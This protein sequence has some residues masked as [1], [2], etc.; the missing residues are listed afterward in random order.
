MPIKN[1][2]TLDGAIEVLNRALK[3]DPD[4]V[5]DLFLNHKVQCNDKMAEDE[6]IQVGQRDGHYTIGPLGIINGIFGIDDGVYNTRFGAIAAEVDLDTGKIVKFS[7]VDYHKVAE[8]IAKNKE[9]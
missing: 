5:N 9:L 8:N 6:T 3:N 4:A 2:I 7:R 1:I